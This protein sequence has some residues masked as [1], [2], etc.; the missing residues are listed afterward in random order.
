MFT[1]GIAQSPHAGAAAAHLVRSGVVLA[2]AMYALMA[3]ASC[4]AG[5]IAEAPLAP[6]HAPRGKTLFVQLP[7]EATGIRTENRYDD[8]RMRAELFQEFQT[9]SI[10]TGVAIGDYDGD[11][12]PDLFVVSKTGSCRL[13]RNLGGWKFED[14]TERAGV[15]DHGAGEKIWKQGVTFV[16]VN[17]DGRLDIYVCRFNAPNLLYINQGDGTFKEMAHAYGLDISDSSVMA[18]FSDYD[19][20]KYPG[21]RQPSWRTARPP[22]SQQPQWYVHGRDRSRWYPR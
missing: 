15:A 22:A 7:P 2:A 14:V 5:S 8:P 19:H 17:N 6:P 4:P 1:D 12:R 9:G 11:G 20:D 21:F 18:A 16:D 3:H 10:G 13:F